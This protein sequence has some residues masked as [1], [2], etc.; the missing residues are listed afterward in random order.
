MINA[1]IQRIVA[2]GL[3]LLVWL[4][5][6]QLGWSFWVTLFISIPAVVHVTAASLAIKFILLA[7]VGRNDPAPR[8]SW[9]E[10]WVAYGREVW[11]CCIVFGWW[12]P[13]RH[14]ALANNLSTKQA[15]KPQRGI[16]LVH[17]YLCNRALWT[18]WLLR[19]KTEQRV[20]IAVDLEPPFGSIGDYMKAINAAVRQ[21]RDATGGL[22]PVLV[23]HRMGGLAI[24]AWW[25]WQHRQGTGGQAAPVH[26]AITIGTPHHGT[27]LAAWVL[28]ENGAQMRQ[29]SAWLRELAQYEARIPKLPTTCFYSHCDNIVFP[30]STA[31]REEADNR[32]IRGRGHIDLVHDAQ[33]LREC[34]VLMQ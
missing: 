5:G 28:T 9:R 4:I 12:Q 18:R 27:W 26:H 8:P 22:P 1:W 17:G 3:P 34:W 19:L 33:L 32:L 11:I 31:C 13:F 14:R 6:R 2:I 30:V 25:A 21:V 24:R 20:V 29:H 10:W 7:I 16:V 23:G 15:A